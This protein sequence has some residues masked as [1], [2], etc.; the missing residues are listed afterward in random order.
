[1]SYMLCS[2]PLGG[3]MP[4]RMFFL[5][6]QTFDQCDSG[7]KSMFSKFS[8]SLQF[9]PPIYALAA[10]IIICASVVFMHYVWVFRENEIY[11]GLICFPNKIPS[12]DWVSLLWA[13][14][15]VDFSLK[16]FTMFVKSLLI[17]LSSKSMRI[18]T[19]SV[20]LVWIE[21]ISQVY[22]NIPPA[23]SWFRHLSADSSPA[24][25]QS[26]GSRIFFCILYGLLKLFAC[27][28][29]IS[30][31]R[32]IFSPRTFA[33]PYQ[34]NYA[35]ST[36]DEEMCT[37]CFESFSKTVAVLGCNVSF[38]RVLSFLSLF[39]MTVQH[40]FCRDCVD[41]WLIHFN[42]CPLCS[43]N[44]GSDFKAWRDGSTSAL[45]QFF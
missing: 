25:P 5:P 14:I 11:L 22:R 4:F 13:V 30:N 40:K 21:F 27:G 8:P 17:F 1:M 23:V 15:V 3:D 16:I 18:S 37:L 43:H 39:L 33:P 12:D 38:T 34:T 20:V 7:S 36:G 29:L 26:L 41:R 45:V 2:R 28:M 32:P 19:R 10:S 31:M 35:M 6:Q 42:E 44:L 9:E 24:D